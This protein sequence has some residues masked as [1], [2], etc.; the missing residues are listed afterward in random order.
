MTHCSVITQS[1]EIIYPSCNFFFFKYGTYGKRFCTGF[2]RIP[3]IVLWLIMLQNI[4]YCNMQK[5]S[6]TLNVISM[7]TLSSSRVMLWFVTYVY[8]LST[9]CEKYLYAGLFTDRLFTTN[10]RYH[11]HCSR[12][13]KMFSS[14]VYSN[15]TVITLIIIII[16]M[17][18][19]DI[20]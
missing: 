9:S 4:D 15:K 16:I 10:T 3:C 19:L 18:Y 12:C 14:C 13:D 17:S 5:M 8:R 11:T 7:S 20:S 1:F 6:S 2:V